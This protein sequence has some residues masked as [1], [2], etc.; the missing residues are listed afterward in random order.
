MGTS[1]ETFD[2]L[3][4]EIVSGKYQP[5]DL[6]DPRQLAEEHLISVAPVR[7]AMLRLSERGLLR[8]ERNR[9]FFVE[10]ISSSTAL[11]HLDQLRSHYA[12][13]IGR[14]NGTKGKLNI[15][16]ELLEDVDLHDV[17]VYRTWQNSLAAA[18]FSEPEREYIRSVWDRIWLYRN[19]YLQHE[20]IRKR[21][22]RS[23]RAVA[24]VLADHEYDKGLQETN[25]IFEYIMGQF[26]DI[27]SSMK[28]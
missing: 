12:Y 3:R 21:L 8:W 18:L 2:V 7:E 11:F 17:D 6:F 15:R 10:K 14:L 26:P 5:L 13:A 22:Y 23:S 9:G 4:R 1:V 20:E 25:A 16:E 24:L 27:L 28:D 19:H